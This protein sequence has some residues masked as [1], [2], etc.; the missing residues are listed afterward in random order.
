MARNELTR[1]ARSHSDLVMTKY[2]QM[3][4]CEVAQAMDCD[5]STVSRLVGNNQTVQTFN[6]IAATKCGVYDTETQIAIDKK[7][8]ELLLLASEGFAERL[9]QKYLDK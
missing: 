4:Q 8:L 2:Y 7:E 3:K 1:S 5:P 9:R 6:L